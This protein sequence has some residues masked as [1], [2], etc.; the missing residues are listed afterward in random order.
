MADSSD[1][2]SQLQEATQEDLDASMDAGINLES[3]TQQDSMNIDGANEST[4]ADPLGVG[5]E[6][7]EPRIPVKKDATLRE[8]LNKMDDYAPIVRTH[9]PCPKPTPSAQGSSQTRALTANQYRS[10]TR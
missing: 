6:S 8:F 9:S 10:P 2:P 3:T 7:S 1:A 4:Q 5:A